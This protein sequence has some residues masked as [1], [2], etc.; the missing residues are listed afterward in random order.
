MDKIAYVFFSF[1]AGM[2]FVL[3]ILSFINADN[4]ISNQQEIIKELC[5]KQTPHNNPVCDLGMLL[6]DK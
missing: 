2:L 1:I 6:I 3:I 4:K 5:Q